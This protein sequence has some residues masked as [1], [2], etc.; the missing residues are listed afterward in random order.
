MKPVVTLIYG[1]SFDPPHAVH[2]RSAS[3]AADAVGASVIVVL[4]A[5]V[6]PQRTGA[7][8]SQALHR[9]QMTRLAFA[10]EPR[11]LIDDREIR[12]GGVSYTVDTLAELA[13][14]RP[15]EILRLL[16]GGDQAFNFNSWREPQRIEML[17]EP[18]V[19]PR[20]P[21]NAAALRLQLR[22]LLGSAA[23]PWMQRVLEI[24]PVEA[25]S[26]AV[27]A[28]VAGGLTPP[29]AFL[30]PEVAAYALRHKLYRLNEM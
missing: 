23:I 13:A 11:A 17:A 26:T 28:M 12:R 19:V 16:I 8:P 9:L 14:E 7:P 21:F 3:L 18:V 22:R 6:N 15:N 5:G 10:A 1:G 25:S 24:E 27:R 30:L 2:A 29:A 4:P 20:P